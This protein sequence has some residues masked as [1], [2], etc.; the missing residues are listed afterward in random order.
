MGNFNAST[1]HLKALINT[2]PKNYHLV[3]LATLKHDDKM[4]FRSV[5]ILTSN[6]TID[7]LQKIPESLG[8][9][10]YLLLIQYV[11]DSYLDKSLTVLERNYKIFYALFFLRQWRCW[12][13]QS[14]TYNLTDN[15]VSLNAYTCIEID[16]HAMLKLTLKHIKN[17][18]LNT[19]FPWLLGSQVCE[20]WFRAARSLTSTFSTVI[21]F[22]AKEFV[23]RS[24]KIEFLHEATFD[25]GEEYCFPRTNSK[26]SHI[27]NNEI[28]ADQVMKAIERARIESAESVKRL[29]MIVDTNSWKICDIKLADCSEV[30]K[31]LDPLPHTNM[32][33]PSTS[34]LFNLRPE[35]I[36]KIKNLGFQNIDSNKDDAELEESHL[37]KLKIA[38]ESLIIKKTCLV[39][40]FSEKGERIS[41]DRIYRFKNKS[42]K[43]DSKINLEL[44]SYYAIYYEDQYYIGRLIKIQNK[45]YCFKFLKKEISVYIW[46]KKDDIAEVEVDFIFF[47][48]IKLL[49]NH[50]FSLNTDTVQKIEKQYKQMKYK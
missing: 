28:S 44:E 48:P 16:A 12:I 11:L 50:P 4:N 34:L 38:G 45:K 41:T 33:S 21:N 14:K 49:G 17:S 46:P 26:S 24:R 36:E 47:G 42:N 37:V 18:T 3:T 1:T 19:F 8:T 6:R 9:Q 40:I 29:G 2:L 10:S 32:V 25:L 30:P 20:S 5:Q 13:K 43:G 39:W 23:E 15:F 35:L 7:C 27:R 22:T 31:T